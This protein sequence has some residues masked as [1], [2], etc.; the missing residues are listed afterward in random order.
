M[1]LEAGIGRRRELA[2]DEASGLAGRSTD[3]GESITWAVDLQNTGGVRAIGPA[4]VGEDI[5]TGAARSMLS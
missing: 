3:T 5:L 4:D 1:L 2:L